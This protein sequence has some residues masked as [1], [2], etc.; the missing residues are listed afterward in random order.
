MGRG[1]RTRLVQRLGNS[2]RANSAKAREKV[3]SLQSSAG[4]SQPHSRRNCLSTLSR[5]IGIEVVGSPIT[6]LATKARG[7]ACLECATRFLIDSS[8]E[9]CPHPIRLGDSPRK[10]PTELARGRLKN[11]HSEPIIQRVTAI[12][13]VALQCT[14]A[15]SL[16]ILAATLLRL[17][18]PDRAA[19]LGDLQ[20]FAQP[21]I[22][23]EALFL[24][25]LWMS[26][27]QDDWNLRPSITDHAH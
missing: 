6:A 19:E 22:G 3:A 12:L 5:S 23:Q 17:A 26:A 24:E 27:H 7:S 13:Q 1:A 10:H 14:P 20:R 9:A 8:V 4:R 21:G 25:K 15:A 11:S 16:A 2:L 18:H